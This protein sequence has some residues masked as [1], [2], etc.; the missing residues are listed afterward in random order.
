MSREP[1]NN[2]VAKAKQDA[3]SAAAVQTNSEGVRVVRCEA[4]SKGQLIMQLA[5][6][7]WPGL[8]ELL[9]DVRD[10]SGMLLQPAHIRGIALNMAQELVN[11]Q[12]KK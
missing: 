1:I 10:N 2:W 6:K 7:I 5:D 8:R 11:Q 12:E 3:S 9:Q 4:P